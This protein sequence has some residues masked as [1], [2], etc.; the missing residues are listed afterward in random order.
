MDMFP[1]MENPRKSPG[2]QSPSPISQL[3]K[4][5]VFTYEDLQFVPE[6]IG[7]MKGGSSFLH[8]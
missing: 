2:F 5:D 6:K 4:E 3:E 1:L 7:E 8:K